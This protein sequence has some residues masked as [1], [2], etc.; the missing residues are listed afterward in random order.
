MEDWQKVVAWHAAEEAMARAGEQ[1]VPWP[2][3]ALGIAGALF[4]CSSTGYT[5]YHAALWIGA[6][7][8]LAGMI[9][10]GVAAVTLVS[11][12]GR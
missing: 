1:R 2:R 12:G 6:D 5:S 11:V 10:F 7:V 9:S 3:R 4:L 8:E